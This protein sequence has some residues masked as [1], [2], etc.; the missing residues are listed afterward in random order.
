MKSWE[1]ARLEENLQQQREAQI[2]ASVRTQWRDIQE[3]YPESKVPGVEQDVAEMLQ[4]MQSEGAPGDVEKAFLAV[5]GT[6]LLEGRTA[7]KTAARTAQAAA[8]AATP[9]APPSTGGARSVPTTP[10]TSD[11]DQIARQQRRSPLGQRIQQ[12]FGKK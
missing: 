4:R 10:P 2:V 3:R 8:A 5:R 6:A 7:A 1:Y 12:A 9:A 11:I